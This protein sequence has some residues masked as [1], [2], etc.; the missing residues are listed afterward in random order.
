M[1]SLSV[2]FPAYNEEA[3][4]GGALED[5]MRDIAPVVPDL[6]VIVVDDG[7]RDRTSEI[8]SAFAAKDPR[9]KVIRQINQGHGPALANGLDAAT[10]DWL[11]L[12]DSDRQISLAGFKRH[13]DMTG[14]ADAILGM[15]RPRHDAWH[16]KIFSMGM[17]ILLWLRLGVWTGDAGTPYKLVRADVW[18]EARRSM[19]PGCCIP[20]VLLAASALRRKDIRVVEVPIEH[21]ARELGETTLNLR[22]LARYA[23]EG[24]A[25]V[26][27]FRKRWR[28]EATGR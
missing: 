27:Y 1:P 25:D 20:S 26:E 10:G 6:E 13:W 8:A 5:V 24:S 2:V 7:S 14:G 18:R 11:L 15:R 28:P 22:R 16:R 12:I 4:I 21:K 9:V 17:R 19:R 23:R 3:N